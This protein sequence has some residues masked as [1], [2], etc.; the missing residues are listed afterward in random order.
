MPPKALIDVSSRFKRG[1][2]RPVVPRRIGLQG[3]ITEQ[4][5]ECAS[6]SNYGAFSPSEAELQADVPRDPPRMK[7]ETHGLDDA[8]DIA[9]EFV[10]AG[11]PGNAYATQFV[12]QRFVALND[13]AQRKEARSEECEVEA[14]IKVQLD[15]DEIEDSEDSDT[16][17]QDGSDDEEFQ[18]QEEATSHQGPSLYSRIITFIFN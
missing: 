2:V 7:N 10:C 1:L 4:D 5:L 9:K 16:S 13:I 17:T 11:A 8:R 12:K 6:M 18:D 15:E 3:E 14:M